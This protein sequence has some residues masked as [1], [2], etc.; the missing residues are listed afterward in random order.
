[1]PIEAAIE[2]SIRTMW[3]DHADPLSLEQLA[4]TALYSKF[5]YSRMF[6]E[7]TGTS[8]GRFLTAIRLFTAKQRLLETD[9]SVTDITHQVG[10]S[11]LGT[12][13][14]RFTRSVGISPTRYRV[15]APYGL[16]P[17]PPSDPSSHGAPGAVSTVT[18]RLRIPADAG[19]LRVYVGAFSTPIVEGYPQS[20]DVVDECR[21]FRLD[22]P[23]GLWFIRAAAVGLDDVGPRPQLRLPRLVGKAWA[24]R[25]R[26]GR[27]YRA[28]VQL[29]AMT[30]LDLPILL[31]LPE[32]DGAGYAGV[33]IVR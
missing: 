28:D 20:W 13:T 31:A 29:R 11:S 10:Y 2:R 15:L 27:V 1:M 4:E 9:T 5:H 17:L 3:S 25:A 32:L 16:P 33:P 6:S 14:S 12:F 8:P 22:V 30:P 26:A 18:G 24:V 19:P 7:M 23:D 21:P